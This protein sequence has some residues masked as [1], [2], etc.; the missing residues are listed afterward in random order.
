MCIGATACRPVDPIEKLSVIV[1]WRLNSKDLSQKLK[2]NEKLF[3]KFTQKGRH[4]PC[5][6]VL[7]VI[8]FYVSWSIVE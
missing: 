5:V 7:F 6:V 2:R 8:L 4:V 1:W 3:G